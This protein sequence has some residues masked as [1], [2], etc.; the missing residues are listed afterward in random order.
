MYPFRIYTLLLL[1]GAVYGF[2]IKR[3][4][5]PIDTTDSFGLD[6]VEKQVD[7][8]VYL[9][10]NFEKNSRFKHPMLVAVAEQKL[11]Y[12]LDSSITRCLTYSGT[13]SSIQSQQLL[14][15]VQRI[16]SKLE[17]SLAVFIDLQQEFG[18]YLGVKLLI[19][20]IY[21]LIEIT[22]NATA[23]FS[24]HVHADSSDTLEQ[25]QVAIHAVFDHALAK[26]K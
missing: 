13:Y 12:L 8:I 24:G 15:R 7:V 23:C 2:V 20:R 5:N 25:L 16:V 17:I 11:E 10:T 26:L 14:A 4:D 18:I 9:A 3:S 6:A 19:E 22:D 21:K 1:L